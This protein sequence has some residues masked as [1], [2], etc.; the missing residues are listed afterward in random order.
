[1]AMIFLLYNTTLAFGWLIGVLPWDTVQYQGLGYCYF[2]PNLTFSVLLCNVANY[3]SQNSLLVR[4]KQKALLQ[5]R[6]LGRGRRDF[7]PVCLL[8]LFIRPLCQHF[9]PVSSFFYYFAC[10]SSQKY[11]EQPGHPPLSFEALISYTL[12]SLGLRGGSCA[13]DFCITSVFLFCS[14]GPKT[15][16]NQFFIFNSLLGQTLICNNRNGPRKYILKDRILELVQLCS[17]P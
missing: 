2:T 14:L 15:I 17:W 4:L 13:Q 12:Y 3:I 1:M 16:C 5:N 6:E 9:V 7:H 8:F 10:L 11:V